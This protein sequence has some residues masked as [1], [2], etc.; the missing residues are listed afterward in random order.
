MAPT[1]IPEYAGMF[2]TD[3]P[4]YATDIPEYAG[5]SPTDIPEYAT[6]IPDYAVMSPTDNPE[7]ATDIPEYAGMSPTDIPEYA[8]ISVSERSRVF[9]ELDSFK[10]CQHR[11]IGCSDNQDFPK[12]CKYRQVVLISPPL[13]Y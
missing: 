10:N 13:V 1:D 8:G 7:Y 12:K 11:C 9:A 6:D 2:P 5:M 4:E 3:N